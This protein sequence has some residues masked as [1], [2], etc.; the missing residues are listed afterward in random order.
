[1]S[2]RNLL[3][4]LIA[5]AVGVIGVVQYHLSQFS[6]RLDIVFG[7]RG[8]ARLILY[9]CEHWYQALLGKASLFSPQSFYPSKGTLAYSDLLLGYAIPYSILRGLGFEMFL[10]L[11]I[12]V[13]LVN[14]F[15]YVACL[16][17]LHKVLRLNLLASAACAAFFAFN[18]PKFFQLGHLQLQFVAFL[19]LVLSFIVLFARRAGTISQ[20]QAAV[21]LS[22]AGLFLNLKLLTAFYHAWF[23][24]LWSFLF[25]LLALALPKS[26]RFLSR[27]VKRYWLAMLVSGATF[28]IGLM[29]FLFAYLPTLRTGDWYSYKNVLEM[30]PEWWSF[31]SMGDGNYVWGWLTTAIRP[32]PWPIY[33]GELMVG[34]G[35]IPSLTW[36]LITLWGIWLIRPRSRPENSTAA[37]SLAGSQN[38]R[39]IFLPVLILATSLFFVLGLKFGS[40]HSAWYFV[41]NTFPGA[42]AIRAVSRYVI[43]LTLPM[44]I[45]FACAMD[46]AIKRVADWNSQPRRI[47]AVSAMVL[48]AGFGIFEQFGVVKTGGTGFSKTTET[49]YLK[50]MAE[51]LPSDCAAFYVTARR[52]D[53][54]NAFE[55]QYDAM[56]ISAMTGIPTLNGSSGQFPKEWFG[57]YA[58]KDPSYENNVQ[59]WIQRHNITGKV[60]RLALN[61]PVEAFDGSQEKPT[62]ADSIF[63]RRHY[64]D[65]F[66]RNP[67]TDEYNRWVNRLNECQEDACSPSDV[68][69]E[70]LQS[71]PFPERASFIVR[72]H[73]VVFGRMPTFEEFNVH[74]SRLTSLTKSVSNDEAAKETFI[75]EFIKRPEFTARHQ[76]SHP[77]FSNKLARDLGISTLA[78]SVNVTHDSTDTAKLLLRAVESREVSAKL[79][80]RAFVALHYF[81][82]LQREA[83][84]PGL[85]SWLEVLKKTGDPKAITAGFVNSDEYRQSF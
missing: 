85:E 10:S 80:N 11:E 77:E 73:E 7:N 62:N 4:W 39:P 41:Y 28:L 35:L 81:G 46:M 6:S 18:S 72:L 76:I 65:F 43:F 83:D 79:S 63:V 23:F 52:N 47:G 69:F 54:H 38:F 64:Y 1:M 8:D 2:K 42:G 32:E 37:E 9:T 25:L 75:N 71:S 60:C 58:V 27:V 40:A 12:V 13:I 34:I 31:L 5:F 44:S 55:F 20:R 24:L 61:P 53:P 48:F 51:K 74:F 19:P 15:N 82:Y 17:L 36:L 45:G 84:P 21:Y 78:T 56:L 68:S 33:W 16:V 22:L 49:K 26:R 70:L 3:N 50:A 29:P 14:A 59:Q 30:I 57:L 66:G 67:T